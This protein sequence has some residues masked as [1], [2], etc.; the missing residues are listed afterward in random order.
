[1]L[2]TGAAGNL[3]Q[4]H[5]D[6]PTQWDAWDLDDHYRRSVV[7]LTEVDGLEIVEKGPER[8]AVRVRP[9]LRRLRGG[10]GDQPGGRVPE[11]S[12]S[13]PRSTGTSASGC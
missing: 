11:P 12:R 8:V 10:A 13:R 4:L 6:T 3:L 9:A 2:P 1:M 5:R 7:D